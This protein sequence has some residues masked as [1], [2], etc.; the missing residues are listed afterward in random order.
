MFPLFACSFCSLPALFPDSKISG[1]MIR[2]F[3]DV[4]KFLFFLFFFHT[5]IFCRIFAGNLMKFA[6]FLSFFKFCFF[7]CTYM[8]HVIEVVQILC[9]SLFRL[10]GEMHFRTC[11]TMLSVWNITSSLKEVPAHFTLPLHIDTMIDQRLFRTF[12][13]NFFKKSSVI[14]SLNNKF[15]L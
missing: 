10:W 11:S 15:F 8:L 6:C 4:F 14:I 2:V 3:R 9:S 1:E 5:N 12:W 7:F 13:M